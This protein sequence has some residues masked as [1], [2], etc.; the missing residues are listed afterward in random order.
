MTN[1][2]D[3]VS[4]SDGFDP[5]LLLE[6]TSETLA[7]F[8][9]TLLEVDALSPLRHTTSVEVDFEE[10]GTGFCVT[11]YC[12]IRTTEPLDGSHSEVTASLSVS[13]DHEGNYVS[14]STV[15]DNPEQRGI[16]DM[17]VSHVKDKL[18]GQ[19][20]AEWLENA[21]NAASL[22]GNVAERHIVPIKVLVEQSPFETIEHSEHIG[23][24]QFKDG[25]NIYTASHQVN[26]PMIRDWPESLPMRTMRLTTPDDTT[27]EYDVY[28]NGKI[29]LLVDSPQTR[30]PREIAEFEQSFS[31]D[32]GNGLSFSITGSPEFMQGMTAAMHARIEAQRLGVDI[33]TEG[34]MR[35]FTKALKASLRSGVLPE[36]D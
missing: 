17:I 3:H 11:V 18:E 33:P 24:H 29:K 36:E 14:T 15:A 13:T 19:A 7:A 32:I 10:P 27:Y 1:P 16:L 12:S 22:P 28:V 31:S 8:Q 34:K 26:A 4:D 35:D 20:E 23:V 21:Y 9:D 6:P 30:V 2:G 5:A 25:S